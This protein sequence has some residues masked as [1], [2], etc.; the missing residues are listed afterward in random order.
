MP[1]CAR[2][3]IVRPGE[4]GIFHC[5]NRC[6]RRAFLMGKD[7]YSGRDYNHRRLWVIERLELLA[8]NFSIDVGFFS[9]MS[10]HLHLVLRAIPRLV[11]RMGNW[12][13]ARR[14]LRLFPGRRVLD[15]QWIE[16]TEEQIQALA[17]NALEIAEIRKRLSDIS[18]F[19]RTLCEYIARR[20]NL[21]DET[22]GCFFEGRFSC[23]E[24]TDEPS[25]LTCGLYVDLNQIRAGEAATPESSFLSSIGL[26]LETQP[27]TP[28]EI[29]ADI[30]ARRPADWLAPLTL[31]SHHLGDMPHEG[32]LRASDKG[33]LEMTLTDYARLLDWVGRQSQPDKAGVIP[34]DLAPILER[35]GIV[36]DRFAETV[37]H[38]PHRFRRMA[39]RAALMMDR[40]RE[41]GRRWFQGVRHAA[42]AYR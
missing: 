35:L 42:V 14:W 34:A 13:V 10:N 19:M 2:K 37:E 32:G 25:L 7:S 9:V 39:G 18:W 20:A 3:E 27:R 31:E 8:A 33:L 36:V 38:F 21:E 23:R 4:P 6:V 28:E 15:G 41:A 26:R 29:I 40:A 11:K 30:F 1:A 5:W 12:E 17:E 22:T 16:P 24:V